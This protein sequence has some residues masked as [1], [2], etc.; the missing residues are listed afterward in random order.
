MATT[1]RFTNGAGWTHGLDA[2][3][4]AGFAERLRDDWAVTVRDFLRLQ[5]RGGTGSER[6][7]AT[8]QAALN[9]QGRGDPAALAAG[10]ELLASTDLRAQLTALTPPPGVVGERDRI[11]PPEASVAMARACPGPLPSP[12]RARR[13][14]LS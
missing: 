4:L 14:H 1:P 10:L 5:V 12:L 8:L 6:A 11:T 9:S 3:V 7:L 2:Q 13:T